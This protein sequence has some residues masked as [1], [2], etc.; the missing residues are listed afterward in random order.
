M[1]QCI[2]CT[3]LRFM[4]DG[5]Q[6]PSIKST[7]IELKL[8]PR[9]R[10]DSHHTRYIKAPVCSESSSMLSR[11][12]RHHIIRSECCLRSKRLFS[13]TTPLAAPASDS[14]LRLQS[15]ESPAE[16]SEARTWLND[17]QVDDIPKGAWEAG[18]SRS[19]GP[20][21]QVSPPEEDD[22]LRLG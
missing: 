22:G 6:A 3:K 20:G 13:S 21:G 14:L 10:L 1:S 12:L 16:H 2:S 17:F 18:Y 15:L 7:G 8:Q 9:I 11:Q 19:S 4:V 5:S